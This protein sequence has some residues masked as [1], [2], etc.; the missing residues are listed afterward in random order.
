MAIET[1]SRE[2]SRPRHAI[3]DLLRSRRQA[4][5]IDFEGLIEFCECSAS[6]ITRTLNGE[7]RAAELQERIA[8]FYGVQPRAL[9]GDWYTGGRRAVAV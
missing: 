9:F 4:V 1:K 8:A 7:R 3:Y 6:A 5:V 2:L